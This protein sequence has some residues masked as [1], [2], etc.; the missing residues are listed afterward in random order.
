MNTNI[1][2]ITGNL[3]RDPE[4]KFIP[5]SGLAVAKI[6]VAVNGMKDDDVSFVEVD[7][8]GKT[9]EAVANYTSKGSKI[10]VTYYLKQE[11]WK[12][13]EGK[14]RSRLSCKATRVEFLSQ[15]NSLNDENGIPGE[16]DLDDVFEPADDDDI[17]F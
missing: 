11:R 10:A 3:V 2:V 17:P 5:E 7:V 1:G 13:K 14:T 9:A 4:L 6:A 16:D 15:K 12:N 8:F